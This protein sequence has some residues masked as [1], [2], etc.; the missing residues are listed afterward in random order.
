[1]EGTIEVI[2]SSIDGKI[3]YS[4]NEPINMDNTIK[5]PNSNWAKGMYIVIVKDS[6]GKQVNATFDGKNYLRKRFTEGEYLTLKSEIGDSATMHVLFDKDPARGRI[7]QLFTVQPDYLGYK[8]AIDFDRYESPQIRITNNT[9]IRI[10]AACE[11]PF[12]FNEGVRLGYADTIA[13][14]DLSMIALDSLMGYLPEVVDTVEEAK[15]TV[16]LQIENTIPLQVKGAFVCLDENNNVIKKFKNFFSFKL[17]CSQ[18][19]IFIK[20]YLCCIF[21]Y[22][23]CFYICPWHNLMQI[24]N[25]GFYIIHV[26]YIT[27]KTNDI[28]L[29]SINICNNIP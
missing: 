19:Y 9:D 18:K 11:L 27:G 15:L 6:N 20:F 13:N 7:D 21:L 22:T 10:D 12:M 2:V 28:R 8:F 24:I 25:N 26:P 4:A 23:L 14:I 17:P 1:M 5:I 3:I 16:A 29:S